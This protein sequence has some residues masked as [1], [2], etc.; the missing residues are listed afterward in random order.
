V[1]TP[2]VN[3]AAEEHTAKAG[4][5]SLGDLAQYSQKIYA[6][7]D[8]DRVAVVFECEYLVFSSS[9]S[10]VDNTPAE[11][12][13]TIEGTCAF[14]VATR[15]ISDFNPRSIEIVERSPDG[16]LRS[17]STRTL[18]TGE[19]VQRLVIFGPAI[20][21]TDAGTELRIES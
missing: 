14:N 9:L 15:E 13:M 17:S 20:V 1:I 2:L 3:K 8:P 5:I 21:S 19:G 18:P 16:T 11:S 7:E 10:D 12:R 6:I 4:G